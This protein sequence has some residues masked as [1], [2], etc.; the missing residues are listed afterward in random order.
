MNNVYNA[1]TVPPSTP[2]VVNSITV[3][4]RA[5]YSFRGLIIWCESDC[6]IEIKYNLT[7]IGGGRISGAVQTLFLDYSSSPYDIKTGDTIMVLA[8]QDDDIDVQVN[9]IVKSTILV[10]QL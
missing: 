9:R 2:T 3:P 5:P 7:T 4:V 10:E 8:T 6:E 1:V